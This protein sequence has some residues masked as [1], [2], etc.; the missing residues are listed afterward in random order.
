[1]PSSESRATFVA[2]ITQ[3]IEVAVLSNYHGQGMLNGFGLGRMFIEL[4]KAMQ[5]KALNDRVNWTGLTKAQK[6]EVMARVL[7]DVQDKVP[8]EIYPAT[9]LDG[10]IIALDPGA[11]IVDLAALRKQIDTPGR[12]KNL[13]E[14]VCW[15]QL[16]PPKL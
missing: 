3:E 6:H 9:W 16:P 2:R 1:M 13:D 14:R 5:W 8:E 7:K 11:K 15:P 10:I 12:D 4:P